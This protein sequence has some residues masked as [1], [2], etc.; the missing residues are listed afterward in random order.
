MILPLQNI[1]WVENADGTRAPFDEER[2]ASSIQRAARH[3]RHND[4]WLAESIAAAVNA[5]TAASGGS[6]SIT[7]TEIEEIVE[8][9]L[10]MLGYDDISQA[11]SARRQQAEIWLDELARASSGGAFELSFFKQLDDEL[12]NATTE[13]ETRLV[14]MRG[15]R[16]CV[17]HLRGTRRWS[18]SCRALAEE[19]VEFVRARAQRVSANAHPCALNLAV[20]E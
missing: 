11:Y 9:V 7:T 10:I 13:S 15:L 2:L 14:Q 19:I 8:A 1:S 18:A 17:M 16:L 6:R 5:F 4:W 3:A 20:L 12:A